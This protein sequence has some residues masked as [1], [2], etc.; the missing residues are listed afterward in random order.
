MANSVDPDKMA[1]KE[2]SHLDLHCLQGYNVSVCMDGSFNSLKMALILYFLALQWNTV[3]RE[4]TLS[5]LLF[6][7]LLKRD[8]HYKER[9]GLSLGANSFF[10]DLA[11]FQKRKQTVTKVDLLV[12]STK[13]IKAP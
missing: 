10:L 11:P 3:S 9:I 12:K 8:F 4:A 13:C 1:H 2:P 6:H 7:S 5:K